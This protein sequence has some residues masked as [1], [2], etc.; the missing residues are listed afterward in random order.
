MLWNGAYQDSDAR[1]AN[2]LL[3]MD[4]AVAYAIVPPSHSKLAD[5]SLSMVLCCK[6]P[7]RAGKRVSIINFILT[8]SR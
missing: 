4:I 8:W 5:R 1:H 7:C 3:H 2:V 6:V